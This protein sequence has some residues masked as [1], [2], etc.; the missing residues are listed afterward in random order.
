MATA[1][2]APGGQVVLPPNVAGQLRLRDGRP[3][4][5][6]HVDVRDDG[7]FLRPMEPRDI[8]ADTLRGWIVEGEAEMAAFQKGTT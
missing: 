3:A 4:T 6:L 1:Q 2:I 5:L 8:P 7:V